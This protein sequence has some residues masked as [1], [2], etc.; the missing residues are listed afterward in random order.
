MTR[1][2]LAA[3]LLACALASPAPAATLSIADIPMA[4]NPVDEYTLASRMFRRGDRLRAGC[5]FYRAQYRLR[6]MLVA[7]PELGPDGGPAL[8]DGLQESVGRPIN[9]WLGGDPRDWEAAIRC[10]ITSVRKTADPM[11][12]RARYP[13]AHASVMKGLRG[14]LADI[15]GH[16]DRIRRERKANGLP[17]R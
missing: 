11:T 13:A 8:L 5:L 1:A 9:E 6:V 14:I 3:L 10:A 4:A 15:E 12:P 17:N 16:H 2:F 7:R